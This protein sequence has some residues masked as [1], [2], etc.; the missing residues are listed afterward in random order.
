MGANWL[1]RC[2]KL[3]TPCEDFHRHLYFARQVKRE[4]G[5]RQARAKAMGLK[6][7]A[8]ICACGDGVGRRKQKQQLCFPHLVSRDVKSTQIIPPVGRK[9]GPQQIAPGD[10][11]CNSS[12]SPAPNHQ[13]QPIWQAGSDSDASGAE[14]AVHGA[15][16]PPG[17]GKYRPSPRNV[18]LI[19]KLRSVFHA[20]AGVEVDD[21]VSRKGQNT[22]WRDRGCLD[23]YGGRDAACLVACYCCQ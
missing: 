14:T 10:E 20:I 6:T 22:R 7:E 5:G 12:T 18:W 15:Q 8:N 16:R 11:M 3:E 9:R 17:A 19:V 23:I 21:P 13:A 2:E 4:R 1:H